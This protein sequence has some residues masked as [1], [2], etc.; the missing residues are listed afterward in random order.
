M[1]T[2]MRTS[3]TPADRGTKARFRKIEQR[4]AGH[5]IAGKRWDDIY[6]ECLAMQFE[7][8]FLQRVSLPN[9]ERGPAQ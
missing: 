5:L 3:R 7:T 6:R 1:T 2:W 9:T 4:H 8:P